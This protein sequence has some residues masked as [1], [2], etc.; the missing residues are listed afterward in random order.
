MPDCKLNY[1]ICENE[2]WVEGKQIMNFVSFN[3]INSRDH[4]AETGEVKIP[5]HTIAKLNNAGE[6]VTGMS[7]VDLDKYNIKVGARIQVKAKYRDILNVQF[8]NLTVFDGFIKKILSGFPTT[9]IVEDRSFILRFGQVN[10]EWVQATQLTEGLKY[11]CK[12]ANEGFKAFRESQG[13]TSDFQPLAVSDET[14]TSKFNM[15]VWKGVSPFQV[16]ERLMGYF[17]IFTGIDK[18][19]NLYMGTG[20]TYPDKATVKLSTLVNVLDRDIRPINGQFENYYVEANAFI[21]GK[22]VKAVAGDKEK[23]SVR[24]N[25]GYKPIETEEGLKEL[26]QNTWYG[27]R[28]ET[29]KGTITIP[30]YPEVKIFDYIKYTDNLLPE[31]NNGYYVIGTRFSLGRNGYRRVLTVT[32]ERYEW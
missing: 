11:C 1:F 5:L 24:I 23:A 30:L 20:S 26:A 8:D 9:I 14:A 15:K 22:K 12:V 2:L 7:L 13:F 19:G 32:D 16:V 10:K 29:N 18:Q 3:S 17:K 6:I 25:L 27:L 28:S 4:L 31:L 21:N